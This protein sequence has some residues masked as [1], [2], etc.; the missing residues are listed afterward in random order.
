MVLFRLLFNASKN[1]GARYV[2]WIG[3]CGT[4]K[5]TENVTLKAMN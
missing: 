4:E 3:F 1:D 5:R 2:T